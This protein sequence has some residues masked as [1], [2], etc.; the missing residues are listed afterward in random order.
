MWQEK[1]RTIAMV[2]KTKENKTEKCEQ[3]W[4]EGGSSKNYGPFNISIVEQDALADYTVRVLQL[5][6]ST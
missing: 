6:V 3:Y 2:T 5:Q 4:P 1:V